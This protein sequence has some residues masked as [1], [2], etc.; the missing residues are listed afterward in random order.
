M[1]KPPDKPPY[2]S[3]KVPLTHITN[4]QVIQILNNTV[5]KANK[6]VILTLQFIKLY[7]LHQYQHDHTL[8]IINEKFINTV[9]KVICKPPTRGCKPKEQTQLLKNEL[10]AFHK[11]H[12]KKFMTEELDY[13]RMNTILDYL[14]VELLTAYENNIKQHYIEYVERFVNVCFKKKEHINNI[15]QESI[16]KTSKDQK[17]KIFLNNLR[18]IKKDLLCIN[19]QFCSD[20]NYHHWIKSKKSIVLP[21]KTFDK[22]C[23]QYDLIAHPQDYLLCMMNMMK[24]CEDQGY[25]IY[26]VF[27]MRDELIPKHI[28]IDTTT[29]VHLL[30]MKGKDELVRHG[31]LKKNQDI[32]WSKFF[33]TER[34]C[35]NKKHYTFNH[36]INTD[37][38]SCSILLVRKDLSSLKSKKISNLHI[39]LQEKYIDELTGYERLKSKTIVAID[40]NKGDLIYAVD[41]DQKDRHQF[42]YTQDQRRLETRQKKYRDNIQQLKETKIDGRSVIDWETELSQYNKKTLDIE[43]FTLY[44][45][46]KNELNQRLFNFYEQK[47][48]R[49]MKLNSYQFR[50]QSEQ[51]MITNFKEKFGSPEEVVIAFGDWDQKQQLKYKEPTK[52]KGF[53]STLRQYGFEVYLV[54]EHKTSCKC[55]KCEGGDCEKFMERKSPRPWQKGTSLVHG[56][57]RCKTCKVLWNRDE[58]SAA[59]IWKIA[60]RAI[61]GILRPKY[62]SRIFSGS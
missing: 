14:K 45:Q 60:N 40:P 3:I 28:T 42:R 9:M 55:S 62:L 38:V 52:G 11:L 15:N 12:F 41:S 4:D 23:L 47:Q 39:T 30:E 8:P 33:K 10:S 59:N 36:Q 25:T 46:K 16:S 32:I 22:N 35:F 7:S 29:L 26:N 21:N 27:P 54:D 51:K 43:K 6:M 34:H 18:L 17:I 61:H 37:G 49:K 5:I 48:F 1:N 57:L 24:Y 53:R 31:N 13:K 50:L 19:N 56:L 58:N 2:K 44:L 20:P